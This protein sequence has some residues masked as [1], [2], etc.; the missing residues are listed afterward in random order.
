MLAKTIRHASFKWPNCLIPYDVVICCILEMTT[1]KIESFY[2]NSRRLW[3]LI[4]NFLLS[5]I[6]WLQ[7]VKCSNVRHFPSPSRICK[8][9]GCVFFR[10]YHHIICHPLLKKGV[11]CVCK[12]YHLGEGGVYNS[13]WPRRGENSL[14]FSNIKSECPGQPRGGGRGFKWLNWCSDPFFKPCKND[15]RNSDLIFKVMR[16]RQ[17]K[18]KSVFQSD[19]KT[20][21]ENWNWYPL[22][23]VVRKRK[24]KYEVQNR[25]SKLGENEKQK[26]KFKSVFQCHAKT[27]NGYGTWIPFSHAIEKRLALRYTHCSC[28][29]WCM[30]LNMIEMPVEFD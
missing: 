18:F 23:K 25:F 26:A 30:T 19:A 13:L 21:N 3:N 29:M 17:T 2:K 12:T 7:V 22:F 28:W 9:C 24:T 16:K 14:T 15:K 20:K 8:C 27:K 1:R 11:P 6:L 10:G 5:R 4:C